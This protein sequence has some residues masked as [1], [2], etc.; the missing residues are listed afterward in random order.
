MQLDSSRV[1]YATSFLPALAA[2]PRSFNSAQI[3]LTENL[4]VMYKGCNEWV[5]KVYMHMAHARQSEC[6]AR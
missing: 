2:S 1:A 3:P 6:N 4:P 5:Y